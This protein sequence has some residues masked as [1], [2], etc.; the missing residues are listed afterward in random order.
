MQKNIAK[1]NL[2]AYCGIYCPKCYRMRVSWAAKVLTDE[3]LAAKTKGASYLDDAGKSFKESLDKLIALHC[4]KFCRNGG[5]E[6][7][8]IKKCCLEKEFE[9]CWECADFKS[10]KILSEQF[11]GHC[12]KIK[13]I[14]IDGYIK[15]REQ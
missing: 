10:C 5:G 9:G 4:N 12:K 13:K 3:L 1:K 11:I 2:V 14:G 7:C 8:K 6:T 15:E